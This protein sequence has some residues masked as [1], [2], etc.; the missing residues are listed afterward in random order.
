MK[1]IT[2][3]KVIDLILGK[4]RGVYTINMVINYMKVNRKMGKR[5][6]KEFK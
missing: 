6:D 2:K 5:M 4:E 1:P 3:E